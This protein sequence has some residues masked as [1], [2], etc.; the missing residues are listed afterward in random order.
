MSFFSNKTASIKEKIYGILSNNV[1][2][3]PSDVVSLI[4]ASEPDF[5][6]DHFSP[7]QKQQQEE[8]GFTRNIQFLNF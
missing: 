5:P 7:E 6:L 4:I 2:A 3:I 8:E 1:V